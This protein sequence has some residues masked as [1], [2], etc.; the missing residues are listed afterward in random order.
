MHAGPIGGTAQA[1]AFVGQLSDAAGARFLASLQFGQRGR[2]VAWLAMK[3]RAR[4]ARDEQATLTE[5]SVGLNTPKQVVRV[6]PC[7]P[8]AWGTGTTARTE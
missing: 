6:T 2:S 7:A 5:E 8:G 1:T 3:K 4:G